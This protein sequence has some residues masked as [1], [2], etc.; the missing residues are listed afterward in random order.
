MAIC[1]K[2]V[3]LTDGTPVLA[4]DP[5]VTNVGTCQY[6]LQTGIEWVNGS[7]ATMSPGEAA[8]LAGYVCLLWTAAFC[9]RALIRTVFIGERNELP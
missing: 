1:A 2:T 3:L 9:I 5:S 7:L 4:L 6:V 8:E